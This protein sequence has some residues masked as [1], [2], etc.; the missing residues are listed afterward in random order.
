[1][2][3]KVNFLYSFSDTV[4]PKRF[5]RAVT[6]GAA[7]EFP[8]PKQT[9]DLIIQL[10]ATDPERYKALKLDQFET[11]TG[12]K[13]DKFQAGFDA[14]FTKK[15]DANFLEYVKKVAKP[16]FTEDQWDKLLTF[17]ETKQVELL[18][19]TFTKNLADIVKVNYEKLEKL[20]ASAPRADEDR[21]LDVDQAFLLWCGRKPVKFSKVEDKFYGDHFFKD[22][23][24]ADAFT[25]LIARNKKKSTV[26]SGSMVKVAPSALLAKAN[27]GKAYPSVYQ[28]A[29][30]IAVKV[31]CEV[32]TATLT[33]ET[34]TGAKAVTQFQKN[35]KHSHDMGNGKWATATFKKG[36][37][38]FYVMGS[39]DPETGDADLYHYQAESSKPASAMVKKYLRWTYSNR[40]GKFIGPSPG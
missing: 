8:F 10:K 40:E 31:T 39:W 20:K 23:S 25:L 6:V 2:K 19:G 24:E 13:A 4:N 29:Q 9:D 21:Q 16:D 26:T 30:Q 28:G 14:G 18:R 22:V 5:K 33:L 27:G 12:V 15:I 17:F 1:M 38:D 32:L 11:Y 3:Y 7:L 35:N 37:Q 36:T 34:V